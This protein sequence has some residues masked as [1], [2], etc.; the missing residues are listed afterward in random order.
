M[1]TLVIDGESRQVTADQ[2]A[3]LVD[4]V[5]RLI[6]D[7]AA[8]SGITFTVG[9]LHA[10][11]PTVEWAPQRRIVDVDVDVEFARIAS[12]IEAGVEDLEQG[13]DVPHWMSDTT[14]ERLYQAASR[15]GESA[16][17]GLLIGREGQRRHV[18]RS[19]YQ[20]LDRALKA[21]SDAIGSI[22]GQLVTATLNSGGYVSVRESVHGRTVRCYVKVSDLPNAAGLIG[23]PVTVFGKLRRDRLGRPQRIQGAT[24]EARPERRI[25]TVEEMDGVFSG[26]DSVS[27]LREQRG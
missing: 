9:G 12:L 10:S 26:P 20:T 14:A 15:F 8:G 1:L 25:V 7:A 3:E 6:R 24:V 5:V 18:T 23:L 17:D 11:S 22:D 19:T 2:F 4:V 13:R 16:V 27:W 21:A